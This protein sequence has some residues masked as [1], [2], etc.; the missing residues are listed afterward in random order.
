LRYDGRVTAADLVQLE[1]LR[2]ATPQ[3]RA[4]LALRL[5]DET[6]ALARRAIDRAF[7]EL[8]EMHRRLKFVELH[9]GADLADKLERWLAAR[10]IVK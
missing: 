4:S 3:E 10:D 7:P 6:L 8:D 2:R 5:S 9:Y 1:L